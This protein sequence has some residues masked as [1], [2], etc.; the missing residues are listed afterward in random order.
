MR[1]ILTTLQNYA[2]AIA[3]LS[4]L[5]EK[6]QSYKTDFITPPTDDPGISRRQAREIQQALLNAGY[7]WRG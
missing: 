2:L 3:H 1:S 4:D 7:D 6:E 5:I